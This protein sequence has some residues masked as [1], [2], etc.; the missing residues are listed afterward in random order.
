ML[1]KRETSLV[2]CRRM[3]RVSWLPGRQQSWASAVHAGRR[4][5]HGRRG[6]ARTDVELAVD[7][8]QAMLDGGGR[9]AENAGDLRIAL[10]VGEP[11]QHLGLTRTE[12]ERG[13]VRGRDA[14]L[15][16]A[17]QQEGPA[18]A[19]QPLNRKAPARVV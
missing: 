16:F 8:L 5:R 18:M 10:A 14:K 12:P 4:H 3:V 2:V 19:P 17:R 6:R 11:G 9:Q 13:N 15:A 7:P 1:Q